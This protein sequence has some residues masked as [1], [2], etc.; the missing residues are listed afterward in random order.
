V[1][2]AIH[3]AAGL[4]ERLDQLRDLAA[5]PERE[6]DGGAHQREWGAELVRRLRDEEVLRGARAA[7]P[8]GRL[9]DDAGELR[10]LV[11]ALGARRHRIEVPLPHRR[12]VAGE[13]GEAPAEA[14]REEDLEHEERRAEEERHEDA[15]AVVL[16]D[17]G[18]HARERRG[19]LE[20]VQ[21][22]GRAP[23]LDGGDAE[24]RAVGEHAL[25]EARLGGDV[26][27]GEAVRGPALARV[28]RVADLHRA[29]GLVER[30]G[31]HDVADRL[32]ERRLRDVEV[33]GV[34]RA[35]EHAHRLDGGL[36]EQG[37]VDG[38][39]EAAAEELARREERGRGADERDE[40]A[41]EPEARR[42]LHARV[43]A[44]DGTTRR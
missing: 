21:L 25:L 14:A 35:V 4:L 37:L 7:E 40:R 5:A 18:V 27:G 32:P 31:R 33:R 2:E 3:L 6:V 13:R 41:P 29:V 24:A 12:H 42:E 39:L 16:G 38:G 22:A 23:D 17:G 15:G 8:R 43:P 30:D 9:G 20:G 19:E 44:G 34:V 28:A 1:R 26:A 11:L 36:R 10:D